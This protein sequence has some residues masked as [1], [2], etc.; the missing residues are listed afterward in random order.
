VSNVI[1]AF[2]LARG[3]VPVGNLLSILRKLDYVYPY[4]QL[5][6][7]YLRHSGYTAPDIDLAKQIPREFDFYLDYGIKHLQFDS[8]FRVYYPKDL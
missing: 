3:R 7:F 1:E 6:G 8:E 2:R 5:I 4:H